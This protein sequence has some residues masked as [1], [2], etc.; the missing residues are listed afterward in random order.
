MPEYS[1]PALEKGLDIIELLAEAQGP[2]TLTEIADRLGRSK[3]ELF[4]MLSTLHNRGYL[5]RDGDAFALTDRLFRIGMRVPQV[6]GLVDCALP[7]M[8]KL[9][10]RISQS[11]HLVVV[12]R[13]ETVV[14]AASSGGS[15]MAFTLKLGFRRIAVDSTSG[16]VIIAF[17]PDDIR[18]R[19]IDASAALL[20]EPM[21][22]ETLRRALARIRDDGYELHDS[23]DFIGISDVC[24][25]I[26]DDTG[27][28][29]ASLIVS[30]VNRRDSSDDHRSVLGD[31]RASC[32]RI[33]QLLG[34]GSL[35]AG[36]ASKERT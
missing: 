36:A 27:R 34:A 19:M 18:D 11:V 22:M 16:Q 35:G 1:A 17:Q 33:S 14:I 30:F 15:D 7:E 20:R 8:H 31:V 29:A 32:E 9:A 3:S 4:R 10:A 26:L 2:M 13:G 28:A 5:E 24:C 6:R 23:R 25:P 12:R 21:D